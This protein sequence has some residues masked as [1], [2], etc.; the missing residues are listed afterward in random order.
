M[1]ALASF[2]LFTDRVSLCVKLARPLLDQVPQMLRTCSKKT[3]ESKALQLLVRLLY[4]LGTASLRQGYIGECIESLLFAKKLT[5][6]ARGVYCGDE[7]T[8]KVR[9]D[10]EDMVKS[11]HGKMFDEMRQFERIVFLVASKNYP[12]IRSDYYAATIGSKH[13][14]I[15]QLNSK[16]SV[17]DLQAQLISLKRNLP[18]RMEAM[19]LHKQSTMDQ[20]AKEAGSTSPYSPS[21]RLENSSRNL[22][23]S[24][25]VRIARLKSSLSR[26][27]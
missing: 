23:Q 8:N 25:T 27:L 17:F 16:N 26:L 13:S 18:A 19:W 10:L 20:L 12:N 2:Y 11:V 14:K 15:S 7:L 1:L 22:E 3:A 4:L 21:K 6:E 9:Q 24:K 5:S